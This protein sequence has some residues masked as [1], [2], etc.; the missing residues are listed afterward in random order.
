[1]ATEE[2]GAP[3]SAMVIPSRSPAAI[4]EAI[5]AL[6]DDPA[7]LERLSEAGLAEAAKRSL[8]MYNDTIAGSIG[9]TD[10]R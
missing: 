10:G 9:G 4:I 7:R 8:A 3:A 1:V 6:A 5:E 2:A